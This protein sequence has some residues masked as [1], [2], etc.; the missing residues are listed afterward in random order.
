MATDE[1]DADRVL[2][3]GQ[4]EELTTILPSVGSVELKLSLPDTDQ[5]STVA[6]MGMDVMSA[7]LRQVAFFDTPDLRLQN[8]GLVLRARRIQ[9]QKGDATVKLRPVVPED[10]SPQVR[11][12]KAFSVE[13]DVMPGGYTRS[14]S[15]KS[16][17][18][19]SR[20]R[21]VMQGQRPVSAAFSDEQLDFWA[22]HAPADVDIDALEVLGPVLVLK[23]K[24]ASLG[25]ERRMVA[26]LW[27]YPDGSR[28]LEL[29]TKCRPEEAF[30]VADRLRLHL[31]EIGV[32]LGTPQQTKTRAALRYFADQLA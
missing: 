17:A 30:D 32:D 13:V 19:D 5:R 1:T 15:M 23:L 28:I 27:L 3:Q 18:G 29:S 4:R 12:S 14:G 26:E 10:L 21:K 16:V 2:T 25:F 20:L 22:A 9:G 8:H 31:T 6:R 7:Q 24:F 11:E